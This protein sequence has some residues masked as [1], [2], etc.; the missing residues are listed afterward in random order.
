MLFVTLMIKVESLNHLKDAS[1]SN[2]YWK[3]LFLFLNF[4]IFKKV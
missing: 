3:K 4:K 1:T 2:Q